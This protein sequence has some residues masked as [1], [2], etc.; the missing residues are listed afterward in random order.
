[1]KNETSIIQWTLTDEAPALATYSFLPIVRAFLKGTGIQVESRDISLAG[2]IIANFPDRLAA[3]AEDPGPSR[4]PGRPDARPRGHHH[5]ACP[6]SPP[7][8]RRSRRR[9]RSCGRTATTFRNIPRTRAPTPRR[10]SRSASP[11]SWAAPSTRC[12]EKATRTA[13]RPLSVKAFSQEASA[14][15]RR[16]GAG[17]QVARG[18]HELRRLLR[19]RGVRHPPGRP[20]TSASSSSAPMERSRCSSRSSKLIEGEILDASVMNV[21][22]LRAFFAA[23]IADAKAKGLLLSLH[24]KATMM[25]VSDPV[26]FGHAVTVFFEPVFAKHAGTFQAARGSTP[27]T[28]W[29]TSTRRS[30]AFRRT[31]RPRSRRTSRPSTPTG[32]P[33]P[34]STPRRAS[35]TCTCPTTSSSTRPCRSSCAKAAR[36]GGRTASCTTPRR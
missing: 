1:M 11:G 9:S 12:C 4:P 17:L 33:W 36:C 2:R 26:M 30:R 27:T 21:T 28:G 35:P 14:Q 31:S 29:A 5:Q 16:L 8:S 22:A 25:K 32:R 7:R 24:L 34:W 3:S 18:P 15:A 10:N 19:Q 6:T 13:V 20:W 23:Q